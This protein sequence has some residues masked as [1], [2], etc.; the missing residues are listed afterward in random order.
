MYFCPHQRQKEK[1]G[2]LYTSSQKETC[3]YKCRQ[4]GSLNI[5][6]K[7]AI[8][9]KILWVEVLYIDLHLHYILVKLSHAKQKLEWY[10]NT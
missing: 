7:L 5:K 4:N 1:L 10:P 3:V 2:F 6:G 9:D 8:K